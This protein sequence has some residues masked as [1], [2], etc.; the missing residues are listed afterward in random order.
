MNSVNI[1]TIME[2]HRQRWEKTM[3]K[4]SSGIITRKKIQETCEDL[5][6]HNGYKTTTIKDICQ[7]A[8]VHPGSVSHHFNGK[9]SIA[10]AIYEKMMAYLCKIM[11]RLFP[12]EDELTLLILQLAVHQKLFY[13]D[14][15]YRRFSIEF[16][17]EYFPVNDIK[18]YQFYFSNVYAFARKRMDEKK[19]NFYFAAYKGM[20]KGIEPYVEANLHSLSFEEVVRF[21]NEIYYSFLPKEEL[22]MH[23]DRALELIAD[24][25][26]E[27]EGFT[28][29][30]EKRA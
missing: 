28:I 13:D 8:G 4:Y 7:V 24:L 23:V 10:A 18:D 1:H 5:F 14:E 11:P 25:R 27:N 20:D 21:T 9:A 26:I 16:S 12:K 29:R 22:A 30:V 15:R 17:N 2:R 6:Y 19:A 3:A